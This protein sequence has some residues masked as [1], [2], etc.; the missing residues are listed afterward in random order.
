MRI[1]LAGP[2]PYMATNYKKVGISSYELYHDANVLMSF[3]YCNEYITSEIFP[4]CKRLL[5]DSGA[6]T[7]FSAGKT[8]DWPAYV[9]RYADFIKQYGIKSFFELDIDPLVGYEKVLDLRKRLEDRTGMACI[10]VWHKSRG[11][12]RFYEMC[13]QYSYV[14]I[15]GIVS[16]EIKRSEYKAF[17]GM[18]Q[19]AHQQNAKIHGLGFTNLTELHK[20]HFDSVD[21]TSWVSGNRFGTIYQFTGHTIRAFKKQEGKRVAKEKYLELGTHNFIEWKKYC[22]YAESNL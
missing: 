7:F 2:I 17:R 16:K 15:G 14:A 21:S 19:Y 6:F 18:I 11:P 5:L 4:N 1:Y 3:V 8:V 10:P 22:K 13:E 12:D 9:D 20:Y